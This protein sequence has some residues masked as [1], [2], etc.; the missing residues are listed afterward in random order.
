MQIVEVLIHLSLVKQ[1]HEVGYLV[2]KHSHSISSPL[3]LFKV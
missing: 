1:G 2:L 3:A